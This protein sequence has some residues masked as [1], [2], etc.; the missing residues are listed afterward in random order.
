MRDIFG[1]E[2]FQASIKWLKKHGTEPFPEDS[3]PILDTRIHASDFCTDGSYLMEGDQGSAITWIHCS[4]FPVIAAISLGFSTDDLTRLVLR[5]N[6]SLEH[7]TS[8]HFFGL[9]ETPIATDL[10]GFPFLTHEKIA[11]EIVKSYASEPE[12]LT[13]LEQHISIYAEPII[14]AAALSINERPSLWP[15]TQIAQHADAVMR[16]P[17]VIATAFN[18]YREVVG[19]FQSPSELPNS[20]EIDLIHRSGMSSSSVLRKLTGRFDMW[21]DIVSLE[22]YETFSPALVLQAIAKTDDPLIQGIAIRGLKSILAEASQK[23]LTPSKMVQTLNEYFTGIPAY[24]P[25]LN[26]VVLKINLHATEEY[27]RHGA[28]E[29]LVDL[30]GDQPNEMQ[31]LLSRVARELLSSPAD[32]MGL[33]EYSVFEKLWAMKLPPQVLNFSP[34]RLINHMLDSLSTYLAPEGA[35]CQA[36]QEVDMTARDSVT[37]MVR[38]I[39]RK[40]PYDYDLLQGRTEDEKLLLI[41]SGLETKKFKGLSRR[42]LGKAFE[43]DLG[44]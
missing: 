10:P 23:D 29:N 22:P 32:E 26:S 37:S 7:V 20:S 13:V 19:S 43:S 34:E 33:P 41:Q 42:T 18:G 11:L 8:M 4:I 21:E 5:H 28:L 36:K 14:V 24:E 38:L 12:L 25:V 3:Q 44:M 40:Y 31:T 9:P 27:A 15:S 39:G 30:L 1:D 35:T 2:L 17:E 16:S 6:V